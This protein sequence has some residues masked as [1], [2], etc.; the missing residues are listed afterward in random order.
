[1][2]NRGKS[3]ESIGTRSNDLTHDI[4]ADR[5]GLTNRQTNL[6]TLITGTKGFLDAGIGLSHSQAANMDGTITCNLNRAVRRDLQLFRLLRST[7]NIN[8]HL[9]TRAYDIIRRGGDIHVRL[10]RKGIFIENIST[11]NDFTI[12]QISIRSCSHHHFAI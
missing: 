5:A 11:K 4:D 2:K 10:E 1:M 3:R 8:K 7:I 12:I 9:I 6:G